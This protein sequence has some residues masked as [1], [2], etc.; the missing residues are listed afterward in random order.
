MAG[1]PADF[2]S[3]SRLEAMA[4]RVP[5][6][7]QE[8]IREFLDN[9]SV[10]FDLVTLGY[11]FHGLPKL[12]GKVK[13][14]PCH[15]PE[16]R[17]DGHQTHGHGSLLPFGGNPRKLPQVPL[18]AG[19]HDP[20]KLGIVPHQAFGDHHL[21]GHVHQV[22][23]LGCIHFDRHS[24]SAV[25]VLPG[26]LDG[27]GWRIAAVLYGSSKA[28][29]TVAW[30]VKGSDGIPATRSRSLGSDSGAREGRPFSTDSRWASHPLR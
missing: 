16:E 1:L 30:G 26:S 22:V 20:A 14:Q 27:Y 29:R 24:A 17:P 9:R 6:H 25:I 15:P 5:H 10:Q 11:Y 13:H 19:R 7:V 4:H 12:P 21:A 18:K 3:F 28:G 23:Q 2:R 8:P